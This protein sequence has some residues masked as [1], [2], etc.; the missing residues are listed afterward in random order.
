MEDLQSL[1]ACLDDISGKIG[2]GMYLDMADKLKNIHNKL[3]GDKPFHEDSFYY[4]DDDSESDSDSDSWS[5]DWYDEWAQNEECLRSLLNELKVTNRL[6]TGL[7]PI[8][9]ITRKVKEAAM[10]HFAVC[11]PIFDV[12]VFYINRS[13][14]GVHAEATFENYVRLSDWSN[15]SPQERKELTSKKFEK[16]I[17][18]EYKVFENESI[19]VKKNRLVEVKRNLER[20]ISEKRERQAELRVRHNL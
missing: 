16:K 13:V 9:R 3:N 18:R 1:M 10:K 17:Y 11:T 6:L 15:F 2:D 14:D 8:Q 7:K 5:P 4:S 19:V 12:N 20:E